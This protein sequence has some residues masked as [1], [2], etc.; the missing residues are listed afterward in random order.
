M[1]IPEEHRALIDRI[2]SENGFTD[3]EIITSSGSSKGDNFLGVLT[4]ITIKDKEKSLDLILKSSHTNKGFREAAP[5]K[6]IY[7]REI[8]L[9]ERVFKEFKKFQ[10]E[11][12]IEDPF[13]S[14][15]KCYSS[16]TEEG[17]ECLVM[18]NLK[19]QQYELWDKKVPM[20]PGH[21]K[22]V[23]IEYAKFHAVSF[24][25]K[26]K[27]PALF[28]E[29]AEENG[30]NP[31]EEKY[32][33]DKDKEEKFKSF[34]TTTLSNGYKVLKDDP[35]LTEKL[36]KYEEIVG[37]ELMSKLKGPEHKLVI[38]HG[39]CWCNNFMFKYQDPYN[40]TKPEGLRILDWQISSF[41]SPC[42][43]LS[44]F[45][46]VNS[47]NEVLD[48]IQTYLK[49]Y[50]DKLAS[51][52]RNFDLDPERLFPFSR[53]LDHL[54]LC[55]L[56]GLFLSFLVLKIMVTDKEDLP[57][58]VEVVA[59]SGDSFTMLSYEPKNFDEYAKRIKSIMQFLVK[60]QYL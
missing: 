20:N 18:E 53:L 19:T 38:T 37:P 8:F 27:N 59:E 41:G 35:V 22:A 31:F 47:P 17:L 12:N 26:Q 2:A 6:E 34:L 49:V 39:D 52:L 51:Q 5:I 45:F 44:Y 36:K 28:K 33:K 46:L 54:S 4:A 24:A 48:D 30:G 11:H 15:P 40:K 42:A 16:F 56:P 58:H 50:H 23:L 3:Y 29:L 57:D 9:Y 21:I 60:N 1:N 10:E 13:D 43:D 14:V 7:N 25:M 32:T 55:L